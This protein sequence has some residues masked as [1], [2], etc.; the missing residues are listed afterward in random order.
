MLKTIDII[1]KKVKLHKMMNDYKDF[2]G[3]VYYEDN[4]KVIMDRGFGY[5][6]F[7]KKKPF[8]RETEFRIG[9][10]TKQFIARLVV[11]MEEELLNIDDKVSEFI[12]DYPNGDKISLKNLLSMTSGI[13]NYFDDFIYEYHDFVKYEHVYSERLFREYSAVELMEFFKDKP[14]S[15]TPGTKYEYSNSNYVI[16]GYIIEKIS[17]MDLEDYL[18]KKILDRLGL[19]LTSYGDFRNGKGSLKNSI[20]RTGSLKDGSNEMENYAKGYRE[21]EPEL[22]EVPYFSD[23]VAHAAGGMWS[24][25]VD[26]NKWIDYQLESK[27]F[28]ESLKKHKKSCVNIPS[29]KMT[30]YNGWIVDVTYDGFR[31]DHCG[32]VP[33]AISYVYVNEK[34]GQR[35]IVLS[36][37]E[38]Y[39]KDFAGF[40]GS[41]LCL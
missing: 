1:K 15:F 3:Y 13:Y 33:G 36:N 29:T 21:I 2:S 28:R 12:P 18:K 4:G 39:Y 6:D 26:L 30:Y 23:T 34:L 14:L 7:E 10:L 9:S 20:N 8:T 40:Y 22:I 16:L 38:S 25:I 17:G 19:E 35:L 27:S 11:E 5:A 32:M 41:I 31:A 37:N 24:N